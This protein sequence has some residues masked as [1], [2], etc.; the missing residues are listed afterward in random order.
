MKKKGSFSSV[1]LVASLILLLHVDVII[2]MQWKKANATLEDHL[3]HN[4]WEEEQEFSL[5]SHF[6]RVLY[7]VSQSVTGK[8]GNK[9]QPSVPNC[10]RVQNY[11][12]CLPNPNGGGP[13]K[14]C[15]DYTRTCWEIWDW[16]KMFKI[17]FGF[18]FEAVYMF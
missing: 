2:A 9:G 8:T 14:R 5:S 18:N 16:K 17:V 15:A 6:G 12:S 3:V 1:L 13:R 10:P 11:R 7:D 4:I